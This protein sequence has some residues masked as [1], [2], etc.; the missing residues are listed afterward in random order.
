MDFKLVKDELYDESLLQPTFLMDFS[1]CIGQSVH[2]M[3]IL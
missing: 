2:T 1:I 3:A